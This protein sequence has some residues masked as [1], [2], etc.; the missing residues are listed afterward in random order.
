MDPRPWITIRFLNRSPK[1]LQSATCPRALSAYQRIV[2]ISC[3]EAWRLPEGA[4]RGV[5][6]GGAIEQKR[7]SS[8]LEHVNRTGAWNQNITT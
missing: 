4:R 7:L 1:P 3:A 8:R 5:G 2:E 6:C